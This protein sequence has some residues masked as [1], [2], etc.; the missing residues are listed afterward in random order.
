[1]SLIKKITAIKKIDI[2]FPKKKKILF[3]GSNNVNLFEKHTLNNNHIICEINCLNIWIFIF[4]LFRKYTDK[5][6]INYYINF[7]KFTEPTLVITFIDNHH[8]FYL[9]K[10][11]FTKKIFIS[12]QNGW[13]GDIG[14]FFERD[15]LKKYKNLKSDYILTFNDAIGEKFKKNVDCKSITIGSF[16]NNLFKINKF[17][18]MNSL[19]FI[20]SYKKRENDFFH[21]TKNSKISFKDYFLSDKFI[22]KFL[23]KYCIENNL[24]FFIIP[25]KDNDDE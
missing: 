16:K 21:Y 18:R 3:I 13:R 22:V 24:E 5:L 11:Y 23:S 19:A 8:N 4:S 25:C 1:M 9:L 6:I 15:L 12:I 17:T 2:A 10:K 7:I 14:D 20:S